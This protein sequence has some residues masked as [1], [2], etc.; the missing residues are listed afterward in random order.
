MPASVQE[1]P[2]NCDRPRTESETLGPFGPG[3]LEES[4]KSRSGTSGPESLR[5][6]SWSFTRARKSGFRLFWDS[7]ETSGHTLSGHWPHRETLLGLFSHSSGVRGL[8]G[9]RDSVRGGAD[10]NPRTKKHIFASQNFP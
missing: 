9:P 7:F 6:A 4:A 1:A 8:K 10:R 2:K 5:S 3:T